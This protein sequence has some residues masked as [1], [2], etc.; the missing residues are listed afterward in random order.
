MWGNQ[1]L[2]KY[3]DVGATYYFNKSISAFVDY[4]INLLDKNNFTDVLGINTDDI[5]ATGLVY[6]F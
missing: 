6:Q 5:I 4:K 1:D 3:V 2:V